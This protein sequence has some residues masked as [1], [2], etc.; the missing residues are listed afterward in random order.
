MNSSA[1][2]SFNHRI[3]SFSSKNG[4]ISSHFTTNHSSKFVSLSDFH[5][6]YNAYSFLHVS[7]SSKSPFGCATTFHHLFGLYFGY[8]CDKLFGVHNATLTCVSSVG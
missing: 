3:A 5:S 7:I 4:I 8:V 6:R 2:L 1:S